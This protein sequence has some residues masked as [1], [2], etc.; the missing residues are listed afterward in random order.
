M[1]SFEADGADAKLG[2]TLAWHAAATL[3]HLGRFDTVCMEIIT[4]RHVINNSHLIQVRYLNFLAVDVGV[5]LHVTT[6]QLAHDARHG[7]AR[8]T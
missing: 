3:V 6:Q 2:R 4:I 8:L 5:T 7:N 1:C